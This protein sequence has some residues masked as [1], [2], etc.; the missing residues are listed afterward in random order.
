MPTPI[1]E[2]LSSLTEDAVVYAS[3]WMNCMDYAYGFNEMRQT[4]K[5]QSATLNLLS[6][7]DGDLCGAMSQLLEIRP[8]RK[9]ILSLRMAVEIFLKSVLVERLSLSDKE[10]RAI[11][12]DLPSAANECFKATSCEAFS[13]IESNVALFPSVNARYEVPRWPNEALWEAIVLTQYAAATVSRVLSGQDLREN[14]SGW[15]GAQ[16]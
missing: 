5:L 1:K 6:A 13:L 10:L 16:P 8:N 4:N 2:R 7:A 12:H 3:H 15:I 14:C 11:S 9:S